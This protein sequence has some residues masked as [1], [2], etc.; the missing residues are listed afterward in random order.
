MLQRRF[1]HQDS[2]PTSVYMQLHKLDFVLWPSPE[3]IDY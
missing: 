2:E 3:G 1:A